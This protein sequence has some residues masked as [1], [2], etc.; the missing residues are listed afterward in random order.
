MSGNGGERSAGDP[1]GPA[2]L[3]GSAAPAGSAGPVGSAAPAGSA[4]PVGSASGRR[5]VVLAGLGAACISSSAILV[6]LAAT[7]AATTAFFR[8]VLALPVLGVLAVLEQRRHGRRRAT[9]RLAAAGAGVLLGVDL[10]LWNHAIA[11]VGA[12]VATVL[13]NQQ[14]LLVAVLAWLLL[15]E[16]PGRGFLLALPVVLAGV[17]LVSGLADG[18]QAGSHAL[19]GIGFGLGTSVAYAGFLLILR[20]T[21]TGTAHVA[22][23]L[24]D[25]TAGAGFG[26]L[27]L[28]LLFGGFGLEMSWASF[29]W[30]LLLA[31]L[32]QTIGWLLITSSL[33]RLPAAL[34][35][36]LLLL[37]PAAALLL[38]YLV[39]HE[40]PT[41][42]QL[43]G[44]AAVCGGVLAAS[45]AVTLP[46]TLPRPF[47]PR[48]ARPARRRPS[49][50]AALPSVAR[51]S[52]P[53]ALAPA[54]RL[55]VT[56]LAAA[57][58]AVRRFGR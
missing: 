15:G 44:A 10:V 39:L 18:G 2:A 6:T 46:R 56:R 16:R 19:A 36:L 28:G 13:G 53:A 40:R 11:A 27:V 50:R 4:G 22:G 35:S 17:V 21:S 8:C 57:R 31:I 32:S 12:G 9:A 58:L 48:P 52:R 33:P 49:R 20:Q 7:G 51:P 55:P 47:R 23:P 5:P 38:A 25:A 54:T 37:Q 43:A 3:V 26:A 24:F 34:S 45:G 29:G 14:V 1:A 42:L 41:I 30:L